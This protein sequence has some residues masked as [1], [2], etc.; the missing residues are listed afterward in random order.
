MSKK[1]TSLDA[2]LSRTVKE[3]PA[4]ATP[5][6]PAATPATPPPRGGRRPH[7]KQLTVYLPLTS[8]E[9]LRLLAFQERGPMHDYLIEGLGLVFRDRGLPALDMPRKRR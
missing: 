7:C 9:Q 3:S 5:A 4:E 2:I 6:V 1:R 8:Y